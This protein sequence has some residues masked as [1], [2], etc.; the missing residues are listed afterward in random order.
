[1]KESKRV[2]N[3]EEDAWVMKFIAHKKN[4]SRIIC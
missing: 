1:M 2:N 3:D 4:V